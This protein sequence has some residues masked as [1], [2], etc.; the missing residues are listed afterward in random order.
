MI[1]A[2][3][4]EAQGGVAPAP[5]EKGGRHPRRMRLTGVKQ[6]AEKDE[7]DG[8]EL[9]DQRVE[10][11]EIVARRSLWPGWPSARRSPP[12][13][14]ARGDEQRAR[15]QRARRRAAAAKRGRDARERRLGLHLHPAKYCHALTFVRGPLQLRNHTLDARRE[16]FIAEALALSLDHQ[17]KGKRRAA[18]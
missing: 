11:V 9:V 18:L 12:C 5:I 8:I 14:D 7:P 3:E 10:P 17:R 1:A 4:R 2:H 6:I 16:R 13:Q 15:L